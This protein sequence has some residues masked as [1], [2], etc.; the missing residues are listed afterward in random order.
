MKNIAPALL[1]ALAFGV[2]CNR[3]APPPT[4]LSVEEMPAALESAFT[5]AQP[6]AR[7]L[8][9][10]VV[11]SMKA[12]DYSR[13]F[14]SLQTLAHSPGLTKEQATTIARA[15]LTVNQLLQEAQARG[16]AQAAR[17]VNTYR[18]QK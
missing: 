8:V 7:E 2:G 18:R 5:R 10:Q 9:N 3:T 17:T 11:S 12:R 6:E 15:T 4:P 13:A 14:A 16:D 1:L